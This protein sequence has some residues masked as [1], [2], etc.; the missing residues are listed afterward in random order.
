LN[1]LTVRR[2]VRSWLSLQLIDASALAC[3]DGWSSTSFGVCL[4]DVGGDVADVIDHYTREQA[5]QIYGPQLAAWIQ[6]SHET[7]LAGAEP[8]PPEIPA[9]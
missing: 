1:R 9:D 8:I 4:M 5:A 6:A 3:P 2:G 7:S